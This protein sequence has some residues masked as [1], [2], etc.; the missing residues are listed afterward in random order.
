MFRNVVVGL[1]N[2]YVSQALQL[3]DLF[4]TAHDVDSGELKALGQSGY[5]EPQRAGGGRL[6][7][8]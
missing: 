2:E 7:K 8:S 5:H 1:L 6:H 3:L 4:R